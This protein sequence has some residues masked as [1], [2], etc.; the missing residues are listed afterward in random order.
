MGKA[1][2]GAPRTGFGLEDRGTRGKAD[3]NS[4]FFY[5]L[6]A[7]RYRPSFS[8]MKGHKVWEY[9]KKPWSWADN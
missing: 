5:N 4:L 7:F 6:S 9:Q 3:S 1:E 2:S 8:A